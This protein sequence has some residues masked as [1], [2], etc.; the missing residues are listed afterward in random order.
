MVVSGI[1]EGAVVV[2]DDDFAVAA[3]NPFVVVM[4]DKQDAD[5][6]AAQATAQIVGMPNAIGF[7]HG[8]NVCCARVDCPQVA[9]AVEGKAADVDKALVLNPVAERAVVGIIHFHQF[10]VLEFQ[11]AAAP[12]AYI[13]DRWVVGVCGG[14]DEV[15]V[16]IEIFQGAVVEDGPHA[17]EAGYAL[18]HV[19]FAPIGSMTSRGNPH[20]V[21][22]GIEFEDVFRGCAV[23]FHIKVVPAVG[24]HDE[25]ALGVANPIFAAVVNGRSPWLDGTAW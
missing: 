5:V 11:D 17:V 16:V 20:L 1:V 13:R 23:G 24:G 12:S 8:E 19:A 18:T 22:A 4:V 7:H 10:V 25:A 2:E 6:D 3:R 9:F 15:S 14:A 21:A